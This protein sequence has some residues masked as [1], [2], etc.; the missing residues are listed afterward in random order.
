MDGNRENVIVS[1]LTS[2]IAEKM[3]ECEA[4][5]ETEG[6][7]LDK[8]MTLLRDAFAQALEAFD[9]LTFEEHD[10]MFCSKGFEK[11]ELVTIFGAVTYRRRRYL[12]NNG[13]I[14]LADEALDMIPN[15][16]L[17]PLLTSEIARLALDQSYR[18]ASESLRLYLGQDL[19]KMT[20][21]RAIAGSADALDAHKTTKATTKRKV[22]VLDVEADGIYV[23]LQRT[24]A[25]KMA[26]PVKRR[27]ARRE[28]SVLS[29]FEGKRQNKYKKKE[30]VNRL[31]HASSKEAK[32]VWDEFY[33]LI[34]CRW[35]TDA[36]HVTNYAGDGDAKYDKGAKRLPG[37]V[38]C[39]YDLHHIVGA[40]SPAFG[41]DIAREVYAV[42]RGEGFKPG[43]EVLADYTKFFFSQTNDEAYTDTFE[44]IT[45]R[46]SEIKTALT[47]N[48]GTAESTNA[49][50]IGS[51][52][53]RFGG[54][55]GTGLE[56]MVRLR[57]AR[58]SGMEVP[59]MF[60]KRIDL[61]SLTKAR[62]LE[63][64]D[65][66]IAVLEGKAKGVRIKRGAPT[67]SLPYYRQVSVAHTKSAEANYSYLHL[68][69]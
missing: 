26:D 32:V 18:S 66:L 39:A 20:V 25:Q 63:E 60:R 1:A 49:H 29:A 51:R 37:K 56:P 57:A 52:L 5:N 47:Y 44:F 7:A 67:S 13:S 15:I 19:S 58:A 45:S 33:E 46:E 8:T 65:A 38:S 30:R 41:R 64:I 48:L 23:A 43:L 42:M 40:I 50:I 12:T 35:D 11:R 22:P 31:H 16:K 14:Y 68:W 6:Y 54:G 62:T 2:I 61:P 59:I 4:F 10:S 9:Q 28:V 17:T 36:L 34:G 53:K 3:C 27:K 69:S 21:K 55:W 24:K